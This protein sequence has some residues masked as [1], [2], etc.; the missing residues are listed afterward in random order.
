MEIYSHLED[1]KPSNIKLNKS[2]EDYLKKIPSDIGKEIFSFL[3]PNSKNII[4]KKYGTNHN[5]YASYSPKYEKGFID[6]EIVKNKD[7]LYL[8]RICKKNGK[9]RYYITEEVID[10]IHVEYGDREIP[11][12]YYDYFSKYV[13]KNINIA[14]IELLF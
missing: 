4:F 10:T 1:S 14:Q 5:R 12:H 8:S 2:L 9:Y 11:I 3:I 7:G 13:G 6:N